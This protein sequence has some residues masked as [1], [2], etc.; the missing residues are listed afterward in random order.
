MSPIVGL[1]E[2]PEVGPAALCMGV[3]DGVHLGHRALA[4]RTVGLAEPGLA[5]VAL[6]FDPPPIEVIRPDQVVPRVAPPG[7]N[8]RRLAAAGIR[9]PI[10]LRFTE[11]LR[12]LPPDAFLAALAPAIDLRVLVL[13]PD[14]AFGHGRAGTPDAM[15]ALGAEVGFEVVVLDALVEVDGAVVSSSRVR[16]AIANGDIGTAIRLLGEPPS[17]VGS[18]EADG[19]M[20]FD[21]LPTLPPPGTY[22]GRA[23][24]AAADDDPP[25]AVVLVVAPDGGVRLI[26]RDAAW[27]SGEVRVDVTGRRPE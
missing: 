25:R 22:T 18:V 19:S 5:S 6:L 8:L 7:E 13:T 10:G 9:H 20:R 4:E 17:L 14:S 26:D 15:R 11:L 24:R 16:A 23:R 3:F 21:Y 12:Q 2:L 27:G 1:D